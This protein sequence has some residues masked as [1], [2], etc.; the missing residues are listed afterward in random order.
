VGR[1]VG[2][3]QGA[4]PYLVLKALLCPPL[5][6]SPFPFL[7]DP[8]PSPLHCAQALEEG[9]TPQQI[10]DK[11]HAIHKAIYEWFDI[12]FDRC[13]RVYE[14]EE[15]GRGSLLQKVYGWVGEPWTVP[16]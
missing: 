3:V 15:V 8:L 12:D 9:M 5:P 1:E 10:C 6:P 13:V 7:S 11:Y 2:T 14:C 4:A 16:Q